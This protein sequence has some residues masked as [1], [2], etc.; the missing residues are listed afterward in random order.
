MARLEPDAA[1]QYHC[2]LK[3][4]SFLDSFEGIQLCILW[5]ISEDS[6]NQKVIISS[7]SWEYHQISHFIKGITV[8]RFRGW[9]NPGSSWSFF[10]DGKSDT[11]YHWKSLISYLVV[12]LKTVSLGTWNGCG[13]M[14]S[15]F[16][17]NWHV[18]TYPRDEVKPTGLIINGGLQHLIR[19]ETTWN[20][21]S[22]LFI[23]FSDG[24]C[25]RFFSL[26]D[27]AL[28]IGACLVILLEL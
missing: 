22:G 9:S 18:D 17:S 16:V 14:L 10:D 5:S 24:T 12:G 2:L 4:V 8:Y 19:I 6:W 21:K 1:K 20:V 28:Q 7:W 25:M 11:L 27:F 3:T 26:I 15:H 13:W 23:H